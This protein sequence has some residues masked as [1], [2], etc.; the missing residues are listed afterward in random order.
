MLM[1]PVEVEWHSPFIVA[2]NLLLQR[3]RARPWELV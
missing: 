1:N 3:C 2:V